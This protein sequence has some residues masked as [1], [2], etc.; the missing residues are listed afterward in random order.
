MDEPGDITHL[1]HLWR[2]G[3]AKAAD[4]LFSTLMPHMRRIA[5]RLFAREGQG[6]TLQPTALVNEAFLRLAAAKKIDWR[7]RGH[8]LALSSRMMRRYLI[9]HARSKPSVKLL[10]LEGLPEGLFAG[11]SQVEAAS[12]LDSL[13][14]E[15][16]RESRQQ[17][18]V[19][20]LRFFLGLTETEA[21]EALNLS[22]HTLQR[23]W[24]R[25]RKWLF[26]RLCA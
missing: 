26:E 1:L 3:D 9:D 18:A 13:L 5:A 2:D 14:D 24:Y 21:A 25:A 20:E 11:R 22:L 19:V 7:D 15:L 6:H 4:Q 17:R 23:E 16:E 10:P 8:F 12:V